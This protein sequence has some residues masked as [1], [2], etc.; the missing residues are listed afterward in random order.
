MALVERAVVDDSCSGLVRDPTKKIVEVRLER[1]NLVVR[2]DRRG[3]PGGAWWI[4]STQEVIR[5][6]R[7]DQPAGV[8]KHHDDAS[9]PPTL[10]Q[11][12]RN[13]LAHQRPPR[14]PGR[15]SEIAVERRVISNA[16][17]STVPERQSRFPLKWRVAERWNSQPGHRG[18]DVRC[19]VRAR[20]AVGGRVLAGQLANVGDTGAL[21]GEN[22]VD[23]FVPPHPFQILH[24][25]RMPRVKIRV[26]ADFVAGQGS[27]NV[28]A[29]AVAEGP[30]FLPDQIKA[31]GAARAG[32]ALPP[33][34]AR[35]R[36]MLAFRSPHC[37]RKTATR[38]TYPLNPGVS[39]LFHNRATSWRMH[40]ISHWPPG[41]EW[42]VWNCRPAV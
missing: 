4:L 27:K 18:E 37:R 39:V 24:M 9:G 35:L 41:R 2:S 19:P 42:Y 28:A 6:S 20:F 11:Q 23:P 10:L 26:V 15:D 7:G 38:P 5:E 29:T 31:A 30:R 1:G 36:R 40:S 21:A 33:T 17:A 8:T 14:G 22:L 32:S 16:Q 34:R 12:F 13:V 25:H 3:K